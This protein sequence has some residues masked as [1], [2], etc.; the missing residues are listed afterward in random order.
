MLRARAGEQDR[1]AAVVARR[2][3]AGRDAALPVSRAG[4]NRRRTAHPGDEA[5]RRADPATSRG[6]GVGHQA[7]GTATSPRRRRNIPTGARGA[8]GPARRAA[9]RACCRVLGTDVQCDKLAE[10][11]GTRQPRCNKRL[12]R[13]PIF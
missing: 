7:A 1:R 3:N 6:R 2:R 9:S 11:S 10:E 4:A 13:L 5:A 12:Y 8:D